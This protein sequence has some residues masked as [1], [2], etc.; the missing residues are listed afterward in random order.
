MCVLIDIKLILLFTFDVSRL[1]WNFTILELGNQELQLLFLKTF[2]STLPVEPYAC[3]KAMITLTSYLVNESAQSATETLNCFFGFF[4][5][6]LFSNLDKHKSPYLSLTIQFF[7][8]ASRYEAL[9]LVR[10]D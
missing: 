9:I 3:I 2:L 1:T 6:V 4:G 7:D 8:L 10:R 5:D